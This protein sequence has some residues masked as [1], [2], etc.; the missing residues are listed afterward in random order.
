M[1]APYKHFRTV[2]GK[3]RVH[4]LRFHENFE[5]L[6]L[7]V[8]QTV[9]MKFHQFYK[10]WKSNDTVLVSKRHQKVSFC[11]CNNLF[12]KFTLRPFKN[13]SD[14][15]LIIIFKDFMHF[16]RIMILTKNTNFGQNF[17]IWWKLQTLLKIDLGIV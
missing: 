3:L 7:F 9:I 14:H 5:N 17:H 4:I 2:F 15:L 13:R 11:W 12:V 16:S 1:E 8:S 6:A 10:I